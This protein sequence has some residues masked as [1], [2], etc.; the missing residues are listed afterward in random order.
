MEN[1]CSSKTLLKLAGGW[2]ED[3]IRIPGMHLPHPL[4]PPLPSLPDHYS[5]CGCYATDI[6]GEN[7]DMFIMK[8]DGR[9]G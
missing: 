8:P 6:K 5:A 3:G 4:D 2:G 7:C 1:F 9:V